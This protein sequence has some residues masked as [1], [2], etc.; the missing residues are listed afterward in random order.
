M[1]V[2]VESDLNYSEK[3]N[4]FL[5]SRGFAA[6]TVSGG[7]GLE[8]QVEDPS[9]DLVLLGVMPGAEEDGLELCRRLRGIS[10]DLPIVMMTCRD[11]PA[12]FVR[13]LDSGAD[14]CLVKGGDLLVLEATL[15]NLIV[16]Y[17]QRLGHSEAAWILDLTGWK[18]STPEG[19]A[20]SLTFMER[21]VLD[22]LFTNAGSATSRLEILEALGKNDTLLEH[23]NLDSV[24][25]RLRRKVKQD[26][27]R[28]LPI[29]AAYG[30]G[31]AFSAKAR[32]V[33]II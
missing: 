17:R 12:Y 26:T 11:H 15:R 19:E 18:L 21:T 22:Q 33:G 23:R 9:A 2:L 29:R 13:S 25:R 3:I 31:Y 16:R 6:R 10:L 1:I 4:A 7:A 24:M 27:G 14:V 20:V 5:E 30:Q 8:R 28:N 32:V